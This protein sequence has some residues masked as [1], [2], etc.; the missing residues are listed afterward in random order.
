MVPSMVPVTS[1]RDSGGPQ[2]LA[3]TA[4]FWVGVYLAL[5]LT[6]LFV[7]L[8]GPTP[9]GLGFWWDLSMALGFA[10]LAMMGV[11]FLLTARFRHATA[12]F[13]IDIIYYFHRYLGLVILTI[14][15][16]HPVI[17][18]V[19]NPA[20]IDF[21]NPLVAPWHMA[22]GVIS[23][24]ALIGLT[25]TSM[26]RKVLGLGYEKWRVAHT[27]LA[28]VAV[29]LALVHI[30]GVRYYLAS[31]WQRMLWRT[32]AMS[33]L[34]V[35]GYVRVVRPWQLRRRPY[36]VTD[37]IQERGD[38][39]T[40]VVTPHGHAGFT[41]EPGQFAWLTLRGSPFL[42]REHPFSFSSSPVSS[43]G[44]V[45]FTIKEL[46]DFTRT[47]GTVQPGEQAFV[48]GPYGA[49]TIDRHPA[50]GYVFI[51][52]GIGIAPILSMLRALADRGDRRPVLLVYAYRRLERMTCRE[53]IDLLATRLDLEVVPVLEEPPDD[54]RGE[55]G[56]ITRDLLDR[57][58]AADRARRSYFVCG[59]EAMTHAVERCLHELGVPMSRVHSE[60]FDLV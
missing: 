42:M 20:L 4:A 14:V 58:L 11:Q 15:L 46:G 8:L 48:D 7:L 39:W 5:V 57:H 22:A 38:A 54:W 17:L 45:A 34:A 1:T 26:W 36:R 32:I 51:A 33:W 24:S 44:Q 19:E 30:D 9:P 18:I 21:L 10:G 13:G 23:V 40:V 29:A 41:F 49:F 6:P 50:P 27:V 28:V 56:W 25:V 35:I 43:G 59:P 31:E 53:D 16:A 55:R 60:L 3:A 47:I 12:P 52:G 37:V 2:R